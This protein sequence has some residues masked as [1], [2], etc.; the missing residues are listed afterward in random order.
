[1][2]CPGWLMVWA[3]LPRP[4]S[5]YRLVVVET[6]P[7]KGAPLVYWGRAEGPF[8]EGQAISFNG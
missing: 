6:G 1:M 7:L 5:S 4:L 3:T 2:D 8:R